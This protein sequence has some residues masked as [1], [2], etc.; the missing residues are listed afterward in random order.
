MR[1]SEQ[2]L[3]T[4][5]YLGSEESYIHSILEPLCLPVS[6][7]GLGYRAVVVNARGCK[8]HQL[9]AGSYLPRLILDGLGGGVPITSPRFYTAGHTDDLRQALMYIAYMFPNAP[10]L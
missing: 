1:C 10:L 8:H 5:S 7:G 6:E 9:L 3:I 2:A 4:S